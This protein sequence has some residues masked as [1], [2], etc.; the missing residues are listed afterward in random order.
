MKKVLVLGLLSVSLGGCG[1]SNFKGITP[2]SQSVKEGDYVC[3]TKG[4][5]DTKHYLFVGKRTTS[6]QE[7]I[8]TPAKSGVI[9]S[10]DK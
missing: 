10:K 5:I 7:V 8:C 4:E 6:E 3:Y 2:F 1:V 9:V